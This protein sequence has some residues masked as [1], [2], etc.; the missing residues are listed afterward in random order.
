MPNRQ[1][2]KRQFMSRIRNFATDTKGASAVVFALSL[3]PVGMG[4]GAA[5][6]YARINNAATNL[7]IALDAAALSA[8]ISFRAS[9]DKPRALAQAANSFAASIRDPSNG[10]LTFSDIDSASGKVTLTA[11]K[12]VHTTLL[13]LFSPSHASVLISKSAEALTN[14]SNGL[15]KNLEVSLMLDV[16]TSMSQNSGTPNLTKL[17]AMKQ[18]AKELIDTVVQSDQTGKTSRVALAP[19]SAAV[20]VGGYFRT[21]TGVNPYSNWTSVVERSG[22]YALTDDP[23]S[24]VSYFP[25]YRAKHGSALGPYGYLERNRSSNTPTTAIITPLSSNVTA[26]KAAIDNYSANGATAGH[27]GTAWAWYLLSDKWT[28][29]WTGASTPAAADDKTM[30]IAV[31]MSDFDYNV[32]YQSSNADMNAQAAALCENMKAAGITIYTIGFQ[33]D[34]NLSHAVDLF[35]NCASSPDKAIAANTGAEMIAAFQQIANTVVASASS[36]VRLAK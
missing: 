31:L 24:A 7:Q 14:L 35:H 34:S 18:A 29:I 22:A 16:T 3:V 9:H 10:A 19:F 8:A 15:D 33:V 28:S 26:L 11:N 23:P 12:T 17:Q 30:K 25:S 36:P 6:D 2:P 5:L 21:M 32:Y 27:I 4:A 13:S 1:L 20:N